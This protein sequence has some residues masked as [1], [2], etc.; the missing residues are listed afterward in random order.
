[1]TKTNNPISHRI[2]EAEE[3][4]KLMCITPLEVAKRKVKYWNLEAVRRKNPE[5][6]AEAERNLDDWYA[7]VDYFKG[8]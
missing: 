8:R 2:Q 3:D 4:A 5:E 7:V 6:V 1:M